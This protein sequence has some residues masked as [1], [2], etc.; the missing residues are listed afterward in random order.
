MSFLTIFD[1]IEFMLKQK[2]LLLFG[3][4]NMA[5]TKTCSLKQKHNLTESRFTHVWQEK[6]SLSA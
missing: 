4:T 2:A 5:R 1:R 6:L 3:N